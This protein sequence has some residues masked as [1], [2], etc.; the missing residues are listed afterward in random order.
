MRNLFL[1]DSEL[2]FAS[3]CI[4]LASSKIASASPE[5]NT[6]LTQCIL[7]YIGNGHFQ[8]CSSPKSSR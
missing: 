6:S 5:R 2:C 1:S 4:T 3:R 8:D 7:I